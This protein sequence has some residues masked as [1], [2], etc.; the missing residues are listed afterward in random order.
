MRILVTGAGGFVGRAVVHRMARERRFAVRAAVRHSPEALSAGTE[1]VTADLDSEA[2][3]PAALAGIDVV[4]HLAARVHV[5]RDAASDPLAGFRRVNVAGTLRLARQATA[6]GVK[7]F[8]YLSSVKVNGE[9]GTFAETDPPSP[10]DP[11]GISK[12]EAEIGLRTI[13]GD[14]AMEVVIIR[15]PLVYG[16]GVRANFDAL[17]RAIA[18]GVPLPLGAVHNRRSLIGLDNLVDFILTCAEHPEA[19]NQTFLI[20]D[21]EDLSTTDLIRRLAAAM[22]RRARL[23]PVPASVLM[24]AATALGR[25]DVARRLLG[26]LQV[27]IRKARRTLGWSPPVSV[28]EGLRRAVAAL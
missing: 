2:A 14:G 1:H 3:W 27:D 20:S 6:A 15:S 13:A 8:V 5:M 26:S 21:G 4:V 10:E 7:R 24:L 22:N 18:R 9:S 11:Y 16:P 17:M 19:A 25:H 23:V 28:D 12:L